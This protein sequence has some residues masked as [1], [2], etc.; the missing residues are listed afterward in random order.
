M[1]TAGSGTANAITTTYTLDGSGRATE[2][3]DGLSHTT[4]YT[5]DSDHDVLTTQDGN[6]NSTTTYYQYMGRPGATTALAR[7]RD[8]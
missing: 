4:Q 6:G 3:T 8:R 7:S 5:Y 1:V 2:I